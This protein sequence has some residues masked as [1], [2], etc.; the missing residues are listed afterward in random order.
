M[1]PREFLSDRALSIVLA[2]ACAAAVGAMM[3][4]ACGSLDASLLAAA[5]VLAFAAAALALSYAR[6]RRFYSELDALSDH[7]E[8]AYLATSLIEE[9][10]FAEGRAAHRALRAT[11]ASAADRAAAYRRE[12][13]DYREYVELWIHEVKT[14]I[15]AA[16]LVAARLR[17]ADAERLRGE[18]D[19]IET[20]VEQALYYARSTSVGSDY[21][22]R[23]VALADAMR[24]VCKRHA[25]FLIERGCGAA[26]DIPE[27]CTVLADQS[28]LA[29]VAGQ[30]VTNAAKYGA[31]T[32]RFSAKAAEGGRGTV[33]EIADDGIGIPAADVPRVF[34]RAFTGENGRARGNSTGM[35]LYLA[36][37]LCDRMGLGLQI[38]SEQG[39]GTRVLIT[40]PHDRRLQVKGR[41][42]NMTKA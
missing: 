38:A 34:D 15:A 35:G 25:R 40:F 3:H 29:F 16:D 12:L 39:R 1:T 32:V 10:A 2:C 22:V 31:H 21:A 5:V 30:V 9:P 19:R 41:L 6:R 7:L 13:E 18:L 24:G 26:V 28:W 42:S 4:A 27:D 20:Y 23:E 37:V 36:A 11:A 8:D 17:G 14:P 33:L